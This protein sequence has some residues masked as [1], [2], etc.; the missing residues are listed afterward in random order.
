MEIKTA[1]YYNNP[2]LAILLSTVPNKMFIGGR[3]VGKTTIIAEEALKYISTMPRGKVALG[4]LT[5]FHIRTKSLPAMIDQWERRKL[6]RNIHYFIGNKAPK[7][8]GWKEPHQPPIDYSNCIHWWN[9]HVNEFISF[10]RPELARSGSYDGLI[11]DEVT[12]L[13][14]IDIDSDV[15]PSVRGNND[16]LG[17][18]RFHGGKLFVGSMPISSEG[19][20][21]FEWEDLMKE[22]PQEFLF[23]TASAM[24]NVSILG[25]RYF[26]DLKRTMQEAIYD[27]EILCKRRKK[28]L[29]GF[30]P[31][32]NKSRHGYHDAYN[33]S[34]IDS[35]DP[36]KG[37]EG[38]IDS[39]TDKDCLPDEPLYVSIDFGSTQNCMIVGQWHRSENRFPVLKNFYVENETLN[40][41]IDKFIG[42][43]AHHKN[44]DVFLYGGSDGQRKNDAAS[45]MTYFD[46]VISLL[47]A[48]GWNAHNRAAAYEANHMDKFQ[49]WNKF[50]SND[51]P[52]LPE[53]AINMNN[54]YETFFSM[55][56]AP[57]LPS[58]FKKDKRS[59]KKTDQPRW[60]ATD[61][62][63]AADNLF[64]WIL[65]PLIQDATPDF[66]MI[67]LK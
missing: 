56:N 46:T 18:I 59:E 66:D 23:L 35:L 45:R 27:L 65:Y 32:L 60:K 36:V 2:Q 48:A 37:I 26:R 44:R 14:K 64:F 41:L 29:N 63:D 17:H 19:D 8:W 54:A 15:L 25:E 4:S 9:G 11:L 58:E 67:I 52:S 5:Y 20:W 40:V 21:V 30:Y 28:N 61:L 57:I 38:H 55:D 49:F 7:K 53:F 39:R 42:Y 50:L 24:E 31:M 6:F 43:Y 22:H 51:F 34:Y 33:Y 1:P 47:S 62:S 3:G 10:D 12:Q 16:R 13:K